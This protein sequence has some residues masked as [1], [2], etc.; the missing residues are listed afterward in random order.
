M[1]KFSK[2]S[3]FVFAAALMGGC[4]S[5]QPT[6]HSELFT[7]EDKPT[8][9]SRLAAAQVNRGARADATL[10]ACHFDGQYLNSLGMTKLDQMVRADN[11]PPVQ[12][13][14]ALPDD[15]QFASRRMSVAAYLKD[16]G[17]SSEQIEFG[18]GPN[19]DT[20]HSAADGLTDLSKMDSGSGSSSGGSSAPPGAGATP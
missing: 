16:Q 3:V 6:T 5:S 9:A 11:D 20:Y 18:R 10:Y 14:L 13:W 12:V 4:Q 15:D 19:P 8:D 1:F 7:P 2:L 17:L